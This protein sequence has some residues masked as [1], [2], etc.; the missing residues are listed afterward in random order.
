MS[1][2]FPDRVVAAASGLELLQY[3]LEHP[4]EAERAAKASQDVLRDARDVLEAVERLLPV[5]G[6]VLDL[7]ICLEIQE[8]T[9]ELLSRLKRA[10]TELSEALRPQEDS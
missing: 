1:R 6:Q 3:A 4:T 9:P 8:H 5:A 10:I 7:L 2:I